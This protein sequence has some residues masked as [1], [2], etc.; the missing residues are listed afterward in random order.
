MN[1]R[2]GV[3]KIVTAWGHYFLFITD[4]CAIPDGEKRIAEILN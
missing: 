1:E 2:F 3:S 4:C